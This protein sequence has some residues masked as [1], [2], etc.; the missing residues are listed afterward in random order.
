MSSQNPNQSV[1]R[2]NI[3]DAD[4]WT[5]SKDIF[6]YLEI[7]SPVKGSKFQCSVC[8]ASHWGTSTIPAPDK[9]FTKC[10]APVDFPVVVQGHEPLLLEGR[11]PPMYYYSLVCVTCGNTLF[12]NALMVQTRLQEYRKLTPEV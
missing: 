1:G 4:Y 2:I 12:F 11:K 8:G 5:N 7:V 3:F 9:P 6:T 10:L